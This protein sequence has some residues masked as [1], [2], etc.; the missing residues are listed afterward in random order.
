MHTAKPDSDDELFD[1]PSLSTIRSWATT[2]LVDSD[3]PGQQSTDDSDRQQLAAME[4]HIIRY[5]LSD[6]QQEAGQ[7]LSDDSDRQ[8]AAGQVPDDRD[9]QQAADN[10]QTLTASLGDDDSDQ[11]DVSDH[12]I[13]EYVPFSVL[14]QTT[15]RRSAHIYREV[16]LRSDLHRVNPETGRIEYPL[17]V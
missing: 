16:C 11:D 6:Q 10:L 4:I 8:Q 1:Q 2:A 15:S 17:Y 5:V 9:Q 14:T 3:D 12:E 13:M 7:H